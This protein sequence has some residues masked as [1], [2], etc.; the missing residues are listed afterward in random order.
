MNLVK[1]HG[2][3]RNEHAFFTSHLLTFYVDLFRKINK[4]DLT[5]DNG[6]FFKYAYDAAMCTP[7]L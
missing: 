6:T 3:V 7:M 2:A 4:S 1:R 5:Y